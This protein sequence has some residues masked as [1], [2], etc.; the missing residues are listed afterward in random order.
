MLD[1]DVKAR[2]RKLFQKFFDTL[3]SRVAKKGPAARFKRGRQELIHPTAIDRLVQHVSPDKHIVLAKL[4]H[5][6][7]IQPAAAL[8]LNAGDGVEFTIPLDQPQR[9]RNMVKRGDTRAQ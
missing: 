2:A 4:P 1:L 3:P 5:A 6:I 9:L 7:L 8:F